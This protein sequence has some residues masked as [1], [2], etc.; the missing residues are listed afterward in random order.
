MPF[1]THEF[2]FDPNFNFAV[3]SVFVQHNVEMGTPFPPSVGFF[4]LLDGTNFLLLDSENLD[5]L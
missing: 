1:H 4:L 5:L 3:D 2:L